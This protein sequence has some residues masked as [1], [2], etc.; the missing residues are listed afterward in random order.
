MIRRH[1]AD[2]LSLGLLI[3]GLALS[4]ISR[5]TRLGVLE[6]L[7]MAAYIFSVYRMLSRQHEK[8]YQENQKFVAL[9]RKSSG[10]AKQFSVRWKNRKSFKYFKCPQCHALLRL[11]RKVG[12]VTVTCGKC[13][14]AF[15]KKA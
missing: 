11:P 6:L 13:H 5:I 7:G 15:K 10:E 8:R 12:E 9:W 14:H 1:G 2:E 3:S 4:L